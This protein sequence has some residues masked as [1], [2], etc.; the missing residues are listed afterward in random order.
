MINFK[1]KVQSVS[2]SAKCLEND[3]NKL[4]FYT[5]IDTNCTCLYLPTILSIGLTE[6]CTFSAFY[7]LIASDLPESPRL[8]K[9]VM[10][11]MLFIKICLNLFDEDIGYRLTQ[12]Y[13][14]ISIVFL[15]SCL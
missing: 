7:K 14:G 5:G 2:L 4:K 12:Q 9:V 13:L 8:T 15:I 6:W 11:L 10:L 1:K 3:K